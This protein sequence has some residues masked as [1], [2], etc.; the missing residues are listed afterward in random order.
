MGKQQKYG[1]FLWI[2][3]TLWMDNQSLN[4]VSIETKF[5]FTHVGVIPKSTGALNSCL[6]RV[7]IPDAV[8][9]QFDLETRRGL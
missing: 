4:S 6:R 7:K 3:S 5:L 8:T 2:W 1:N 9:I